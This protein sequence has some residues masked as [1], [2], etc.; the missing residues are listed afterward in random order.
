MFFQHKDINILNVPP[1]LSIF[2]SGEH[3]N[4]NTL[5]T[6]Q[7]Q[8]HLLDCHPEHDD[9]TLSAV[10]NGNYNNID[11][12]DGRRTKTPVAATVIKTTTTTKTTS[13]PREPIIPSKRSTVS[14]ISL[15]T[16]SQ[17]RRLCGKTSRRAI[18]LG[19]PS[20]VAVWIALSASSRSSTPRG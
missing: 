20:N 1:T 17:S 12:D 10:D 3:K 7:I 6:T 19:I 8:P 2:M 5:T 16:N 9:A 11:N 4:I 14:W 18:C 13:C 15:K